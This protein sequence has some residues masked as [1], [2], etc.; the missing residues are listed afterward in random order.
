MN[1]KIN[2]AIEIIKNKISE[3]PADMKSQAFSQWN[4]REVIAGSMAKTFAEMLAKRGFVSEM[5]VDEVK[6]EIKAAALEAAK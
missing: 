6:N 2:Q 3:I 1:E 5:D 4:E